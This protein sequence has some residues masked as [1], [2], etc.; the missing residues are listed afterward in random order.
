MMEKYR[1][2]TFTAVRRYGGSER[3]HIVKTRGPYTGPVFGMGVKRT[4]CGMPA[5]NPVKRLRVHRV[6]CSDCYAIYEDAS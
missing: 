6:S 5:G 4:L 3:S 2:V 1:Q